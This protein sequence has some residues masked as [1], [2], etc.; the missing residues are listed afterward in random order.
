M[1]TMVVT[2]PAAAA[3]EARPRPS[4]FAWL[5]GMHLT[6]DDARHHPLAGG[7]ELLARRGRRA[8]SRE[9]DLAVRHRHEA[10]L[11]DAVREHQIAGNDQIEVSHDS[12]PRARASA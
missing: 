7:I 5:F 4:W 1:S 9:R 6:V 12:T 2:P 10:V 11:H 8:A 3:R